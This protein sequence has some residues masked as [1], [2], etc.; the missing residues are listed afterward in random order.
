MTTRKAY[1]KPDV[2]EVELRVEE[3]VLTTCKKQGADRLCIPGAGELD[4]WICP[5]F[6]S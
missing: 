3:A 6:G 4:C 2:K 1:Q 5:I